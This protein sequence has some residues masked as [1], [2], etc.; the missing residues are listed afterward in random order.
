MMGHRSPGFGIDSHA[1]TDA[2][3]AGARGDGIGLGAQILGQWSNSP[4][5]D[6]FV[7]R[8]SCM[9]TLLLFEG[10]GL[11]LEMEDGRH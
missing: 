9:W 8:D 1:E 2:A 3:L 7:N 5:E 4:L 11:V 10:A 6:G